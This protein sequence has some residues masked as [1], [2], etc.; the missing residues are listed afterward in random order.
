MHQSCQSLEI[1]LQKKKIMFREKIF[2]YYIRCRRFFQSRKSAGGQ[3]A[4]F[5]IRDGWQ[6]KAD[7]GGVHLEGERRPG[8][9]SSSGKSPSGKSLPNFLPAE[10]QEGFAFCILM[11][12]TKVQPSA[13]GGFGGAGRGMQIPLGDTFSPFLTKSFITSLFLEN[14]IV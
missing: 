14:L 10:C 3:N 2:F 11:W 12:Y 7:L 6:G 4:H 13:G 5:V 8:G 1:I 9:K